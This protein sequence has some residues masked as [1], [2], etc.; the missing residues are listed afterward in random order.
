MSMSFWRKVAKVAIGALRDNALLFLTYATRFICPL[1]KFFVPDPA[2][3][4]T[5]THPCWR[6]SGRVLGDKQSLKFKKW[7]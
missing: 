1:L 6:T 4:C 3:G 2:S 7:S 5:G